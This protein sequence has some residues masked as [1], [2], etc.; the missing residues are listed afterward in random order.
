V[1][2]ARVDEL[3]REQSQ[4]STRL[5]VTDNPILIRASLSGYGHTQKLGMQL[6]GSNLG[7]KSGNV[8]I[9]LR[10]DCVMPEGTEDD[11]KRPFPVAVN[12]WDKEI[13]SGRTVRGVGIPLTTLVETWRPIKGQYYVAAAF[14]RDDLERVR[15]QERHFLNSGTTCREWLVTQARRADKKFSNEMIVLFP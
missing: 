3:Q 9:L 10:T 1:Q 7:D 13:D 15:R 12:Y 14:D 4:L 5:R 2:T 8:E 11:F 6:V